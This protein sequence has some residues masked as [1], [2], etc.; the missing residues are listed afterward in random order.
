MFS[1]MTRSQRK[2]AY[3]AFAAFMVAFAG[4]WVEAIPNS[5]IFTAFA[6]GTIFW[7]KAMFSK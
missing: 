1:P 6:I 3:L 5:I 7:C 2:A 4:Q